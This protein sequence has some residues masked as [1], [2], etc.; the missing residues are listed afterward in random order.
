MEWTNHTIYIMVMKI[1][2]SNTVV[3]FDPTSITF[4][5]NF[6]RG[7]GVLKLGAPLLICL[8]S[9][10]LQPWLLKYNHRTPPDQPIRITIISIKGWYKQKNNNPNYKDAETKQGISD[11]YWETT[12]YITKCNK[13]KWHF[14]DSWEGWDGSII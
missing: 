3:E 9:V 10:S 11:S 14:Y 1:C 5:E 7:G 2:I 4:K 6:Y 12:W 8:Q 13:S